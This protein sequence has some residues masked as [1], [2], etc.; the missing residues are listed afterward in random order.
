MEDFPKELHR[1]SEVH[2]FGSGPLEVRSIEG[3]RTNW[4]AICKFFI[5]SHKAEIYATV[6]QHKH[7]R[8]HI[9]I[10]FIVF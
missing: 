2:K 8:S 3:M 1:K 5:I 9:E 6:Q 10:S 4:L 7:Q